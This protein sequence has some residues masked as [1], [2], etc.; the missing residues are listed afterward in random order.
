MMCGGVVYVMDLIPV[1][2]LRV[3][4]CSRGYYYQN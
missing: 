3:Q 2:R 4:I 1:A